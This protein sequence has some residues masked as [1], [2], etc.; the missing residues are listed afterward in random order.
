MAQVSSLIQTAL[1][2]TSVQPTHVVYGE[3]NQE[4]QIK[5]GQTGKFWKTYGSLV[6]EKPGKVQLTLGETIG[7]ESPLVLNIDIVLDKSLKFPEI[8]SITD[9]HLWPF[10]YEFVATVQQLMVDLIDDLPDAGRWAVLLAAPREVQLS[11]RFHWLY[12]LH[13]PL[14]H[15][16]TTWQHAVFLPELHSVCRQVRVGSSERLL[17]ECL[18]D[19]FRL[20]ADWTDVVTLPQGSLPLYRSRKSQLVPELDYIMVFS[21][22]SNL[23]EDEEA[24]VVDLRTAF[25]IVRHLHFETGQCKLQEICVKSNVSQ[26]QALAFVLSQWYAPGCQYQAKTSGAVSRV[27]SPSTTVWDKRLSTSAQTTPHQGVAESLLPLLAPKRFQEEHTWMDVGRALYVTYVRAPRGLALWQKY[28]EMHSKGLFT[29][30]DCAH[31]YNDCLC[32]ATLITYRTIGFY[33]RDDAPEAYKA[34]HQTWCENDLKVIYEEPRTTHADVAAL[35]FKRYWLELAYERGKWYEYLDT[36]YGWRESHKKDDV[37]RRITNDFLPYVYDLRHELTTQ[38]VCATPDKK[39]EFDKPINAIKKLIEKLKD[40]SFCSMT[41]SQAQT[42][43]H[44]NDVGFASKSFSSR[45]DMNPRLMRTLNGVL[46]VMT[47][48]VVFRRGKPEDYLT[49]VTGVRYDE[50]L[51][52]ESPEVKAYLYWVKQIFNAEALVEYAQLIFASVL[53]GGNRDKILPIWWGDQGNNCKSTLM[54]CCKKALG[55]YHAELPTSVATKG[56]NNAGNATPELTPMIKARMACMKEPD[57]DE[58]L[59]VGRLKELTGDTDTMYLRRLF[60]E[61]HE[62]KVFS[63]IFLHC[64]EVPPTNSPNDKAMKN[65]V[66]ILPFNSIWSAEAP[67]SPEE[68]RKLRHYKIDTKFNDKMYGYA[69]AW[70]WVAV[71]YFPKYA[72]VGV[73]TMPEEVKVAT[74]TYWD[75]I[76]YYNNFRNERLEADPKG[77]VTV[78]EMYPVFDQ[79]LKDDYQKKT[80]IPTKPTFREN[81]KKSLVGS[82]FKKDT[83]HGWKLTMTNLA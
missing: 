22:I 76:N 49:M 42:R 38:Q 47:K 11:G 5:H 26:N 58:T 29:Y 17:S 61:G 54:D 50:D 33:A 46:E 20:C 28:T 62:S 19:T 39:P 12:R 18:P 81:I 82:V 23:G 13:F 32:D 1:E 70:L 14:C 40:E 67:E 37:A 60:Q 83:F 25:P 80:G 30:T 64:N 2:N 4:Y 41:I 53:W 71:Q 51:T 27:L 55:N 57:P 59:Q 35:L 16:D 15:L 44:Y 45:L 24:P 74:D 56:R 6:D 75:K 9:H 69:R 66:T 10:L 21:D 52:W 72:E 48:K 34:W 36:E 3:G 77:T 8:Q 63:K 65:R 78:S 7:A 73:A 31:L 68:Q 43:C 79:F